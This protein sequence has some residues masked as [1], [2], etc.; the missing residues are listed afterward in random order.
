M[1]SLNS[2]LKNKYQSLKQ[3]LK[4]L[5]SVVVAFS[6]GIDSSLVA[7]MALH[8]IGEKVLA[9][10]SASPSLK[11]SDLQ[12]TAELALEWKMRHQI[13][14]TQELE[15]PNYQSNPNDRCYYCKSTLYQEL[16]QIAKA[17]N[18]RH[19]VNG[20]NMDDAQD[21]RPGLKAA[22][23]YQ[24]RSPLVEC[25]F[26]KSDIRE[27]ASAL[28]LKNAQKPQSA[29][30]SSR[31]PYGTPVSIPLLKQIE[32]AETILARM[33]FTQFR[34][35]HHGT[36]ARLELLPEEF[37]LALKNRTALQKFIRNCG[38]HYVTLDIGGFRSGSMNDELKEV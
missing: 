28:G 4:S 29:C 14:Q 11:E 21:Y 33:G 18:Y 20:T 12:L 19:V 35:R 10:T 6:G 15:N 1:R 38:Y 36:V 30:L 22:L 32:Q 13:I 26:R 8:E 34:V 25:G 17:Q 3:Y 5:E 2:D 23:E 27:L 9:V 16:A 24:V 37:E 31:I 7:Y